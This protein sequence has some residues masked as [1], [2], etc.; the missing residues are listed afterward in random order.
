[1]LA[2]I[3]GLEFVQFGADSPLDVNF[4]VASRS[5]E[6]ATEVSRANGAELQSLQLPLPAITLQVHTDSYVASA[7]SATIQPTHSA[8]VHVCH[9]V[10]SIPRMM[11]Y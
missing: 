7:S 5:A 10:V 3:P 11:T 9:F 8:E 4:V 6:L 1:M 2:L